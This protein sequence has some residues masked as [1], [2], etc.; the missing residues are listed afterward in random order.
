MPAIVDDA[1][2]F[3]EKERSRLKSEYLVRPAKFDFARGRSRVVDQLPSYFPISDGCAGREQG[4]WQDVGQAAQPHE[5][6]KYGRK[7]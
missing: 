4:L 7:S 2:R 6:K 3:C 1:E 5:N